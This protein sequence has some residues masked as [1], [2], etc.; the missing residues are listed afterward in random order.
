[1][2]FTDTDAADRHMDYLDGCTKIVRVWEKRIANRTG[3]LPGSLLSPI[4]TP[5]GWCGQV[6]LFPGRHSTVDAA[7]AA[8][9]I[10]AVYGLPTGSVVVDDGVDETADTAFIWAYNR[11]SM[12]DYHAH[13]PMTITGQPFAGHLSV[14]GRPTRFDWSELRDWHTSTGT[15]GR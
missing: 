11:P 7:A 9:T 3:P 5:L 8:N 10:A 15:R 2:A 1:M 12:A 6:Q 13:W 4:R 14:V